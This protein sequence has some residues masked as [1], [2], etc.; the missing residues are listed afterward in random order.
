[1]DIKAGYEISLK[2]FITELGVPERLTIDGSKEHNTPGTEFVKIF[3]RND[4]QLTRTELEH[5]NY[6]PSEGVDREVQ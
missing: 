2:S 6:N 3:Q 5:P 4:I 1:M